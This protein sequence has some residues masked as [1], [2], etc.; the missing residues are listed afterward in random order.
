[1]GG[2]MPGGG[3]GGRGGGGAPQ[4]MTL[5]IEQ[6]E[7]D[8]KITNVKGGMGGQDAVEDFKLD[9]KPKEEMVTA[10]MVQN[11]VKKVTKAKISKDKFETAEK[12]NTQFP[13][14]M[15]KSY[16]L[17]NDGKTLT[18]KLNS[19]GFGGFTQKLVFQ[20]Q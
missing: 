18:L 2:G 1:M 12:T 15:K 6:T 4:M 5:V 16:S 9:G 14:E 3:M 19:S 20:K 11:K 10:P 17:S 8:I 7:S 13:T